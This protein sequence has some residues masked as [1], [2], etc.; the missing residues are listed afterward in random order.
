M[1]TILPPGNSHGLLPD[2]R[3]MNLLFRDIACAVCQINGIPHA[4]AERI[5]VSVG[6][7]SIT[8]QLKNL[9][10][11]ENPDPEELRI[12]LLTR[13]QGSNKW[14]SSS[15]SDERKIPEFIKCAL[16]ELQALC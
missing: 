3:E 15:F 2:K 7:R 5:P 13:V 10:F 1:L 11:R 16:S 14:K 9:R 8:G 6:N 4:F 12:E